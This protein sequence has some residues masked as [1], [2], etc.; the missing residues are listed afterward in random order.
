MRAQKFVFSVLSGNPLYYA[1][2]GYRPAGNLFQDGK[3]DAGA[4]PPRVKA[5]AALVVCLSAESWPEG[6]AYIPGPS[7]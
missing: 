5:E 3:A 6:G 7:F 1:S 2:S 4:T